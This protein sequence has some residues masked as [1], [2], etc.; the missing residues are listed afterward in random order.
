MIRHLALIL[1]LLAP[2]PAFALSCMAPS[3]ERSFARAD[4]AEE[5]YVVVH[6]RLT[7]H[8]KALPRGGNGEFQPPELTKIDAILS[9]KS[10]TLEGFKVP[11]DQEITLDVACFGPWCGSVRNGEDVLVFL[12]KEGARYA[13]DVN[14]CGGSVFG[15]PSRKML[16]KA[17]TCLRGGPCTAD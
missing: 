13:L 5:S 1:A 8:E 4:A 11:F 17:K 15:A 2:L 7:L 12:R 9:G 6:G 16:K 14:P 10:L 3:V